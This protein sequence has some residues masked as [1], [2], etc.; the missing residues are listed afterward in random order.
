MS[1]TELPVFSELGFSDEEWGLLT[2]LPQA[3]LTAAGAAEADGARRSRA[4]H[5]AGLEA[6][7]AGRESSSR[8]VR[9][10]AH[11]LVSRVGDPEVGETL[12]VIEPTD[13]QAYLA[14]VLERAR[15]VAGLL[16]ERVDT[17]EA[18]A[19]KH[20]LVGIA[21][22][23]VTA[24]STGGVLGIGGDLVTAAE[25]GFCDRLAQALHD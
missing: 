25:R 9:M 18:G 22:R 23:V 20:W 5:A 17:G 13:P 6:I 24:A 14:D 4:E 15:D 1:V 7:A 11:E 10:V 19:Y 16:A 3:V 2:G 12:P 8:L 21:E